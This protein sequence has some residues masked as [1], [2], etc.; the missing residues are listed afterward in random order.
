MLQK[1]EFVYSH[2]VKNRSHKTQSMYKTWKC[3]QDCPKVNLVPLYTTRR[4]GACCCPRK[5]GL[6]P[7]T[8]DEVESVLGQ[9]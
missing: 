4:E 8:G 9:Y 3:N 2:I 1:R 6:K 7:E 5:E